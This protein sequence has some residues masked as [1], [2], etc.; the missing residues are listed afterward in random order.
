[1]KSSFLFSLIIFLMLGIIIAM[2]VA[3]KELI[4]VTETINEGDMASYSF[5]GDEGTEI[6][7][8]IEVTSGDAVDMLFMDENGYI[9]YSSAFESNESSSFM[10]YTGA[11]SLNVTEDD[12]GIELPATQTYYVVIEN[13]DFTN[14]GASSTGSVDV[15]L[16]VTTKED[17]KTPGF[18]W[19]GLSSALLIAGAIIL[20]QRR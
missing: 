6:E 3:A 7:L 15:K 1:M 16:V 10:Y 14:G 8:R 9:M 12:R 11:T 4:N 17:E 13:A 20:R 18:E 19:V 5:L 2:P